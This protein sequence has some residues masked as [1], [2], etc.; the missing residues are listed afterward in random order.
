VFNRFRPLDCALALLEKAKAQKIK[1]KT[2]VM[3]SPIRY[4]AYR[5]T[6][7]PD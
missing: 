5:R 4:D 6:F 2:R 1:N 7:G 3:P